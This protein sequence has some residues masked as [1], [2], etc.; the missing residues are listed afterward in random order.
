MGLYYLFGLWGPFDPFGQL[1]LYYRW[2]LWDLFD[3]WDPF[4]PWYQF[5]PFVQIQLGRYYLWHHIGRYYLWRLL[6]LLCPY[7]QFD[8]E[9]LGGLLCLFV[10]CHQLCRLCPLNLLDLFGRYYLLRQLN[11]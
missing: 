9:N 4:G 7:H 10:P 3:L 11:R 6:R 8:Q 2:S 5:D 1:G